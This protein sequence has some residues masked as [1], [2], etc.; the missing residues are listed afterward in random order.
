MKE[1]VSIKRILIDLMSIKEQ[2]KSFFKESDKYQVLIKYILEDERLNNE[3][4]YLPTFKEIEK[5]TGIKIYHIRKQLLEIYEK[6][7]DYE[8]GHTFNFSKTELYFSAKNNKKYASFK[9]ENL[10][11]IPR[12]GEN[13][14]LPFLK[15]KLGSD[16]FYIDDIRHWF[17]SDKHVININLKCGF[18]NSY[19]HNRLH[20]AKEKREL[21]IHDY[22][23]LSDYEL[24]EKLG[25]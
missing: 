21:S 10:N 5:Q 6:L 8:N 3:E 18:F 15:A 11:Y 4:Y 1:K 20:E 9:C 24:K 25:V 22:Y 7:F 16:Y 23:D 17:M 14:E 13:I 2:I 19:W 12:V